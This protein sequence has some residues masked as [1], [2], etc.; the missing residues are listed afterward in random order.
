MQVIVVVVVVIHSIS[1][2]KMY[3]ITTHIS[4]RNNTIKLASKG[5]SWIPIPEI[6]EDKIFTEIQGY[7]SLKLNLTTKKGR[8][9]EN[10]EK[11]HYVL[12]HFSCQKCF[13]KLS[14]IEDIWYKFRK[15]NEGVNKLQMKTI[16][17]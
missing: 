15:G 7:F 5:L 11:F 8:Q 2:K 13:Q 12:Y 6:H 4:I 16:R 3:S 9:S 1:Y 14:K 10:A 17:P